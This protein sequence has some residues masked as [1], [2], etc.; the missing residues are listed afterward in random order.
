MDHVSNTAAVMLAAGEAPE[1]LP[2]LP[3]GA[4]IV[5]VDGGLEL[6]ERLGVIPDLVVGDLDSVDPDILARA[7][8]AG[9]PIERHP[10]DKDETDWE[11]GLRAIAQ[12]DFHEVVIIG[13][14][15]GRLSHLIGNAAVLANDDFSAL[16]IEWSIGETSVRVARPEASVDLAGSPGDLVSLVPIGGIA[17][18]IN[19]SGLR[20]P[21]QGGRLV[22]DSTRGISNELVGSAATVSLAAGVLLVIVERV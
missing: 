5:A 14:G 22:P 16:R 3:Q 1:P 10:R 2:K 17:A 13:G 21:L 20:W 11:L 19:T 9:I 7:K 15:G 18:G 6:A 12:R 8:S 4:W